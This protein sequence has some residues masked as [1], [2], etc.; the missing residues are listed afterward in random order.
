[1]AKEICTSCEVKL[2]KE[3]VSF[4]PACGH[5]TRFAS[6][7]ERLEHDLGKWR[8][9]L[10]RSAATVTLDAPSNGAPKSSVI[11]A[12]ASLAETRRTS[13]AREP[14]ETMPSVRLPKVRAPRL[15]RRE[16]A[17]RQP[18]AKRVIELDRDHA[19]AYRACPTCEEADWIVRMTRND[20]ATWNFWCVRCS[21]SFK[22][23][24]KLSYAWRPFASAGVVIGGLIA[25]STLMLR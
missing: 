22:T 5:P 14:R 25:A 6:D 9:H 24:V 12:T 4:C 2:G 18:K 15:P 1:M 23:E 21:R 8:T 19:F 13:V 16:R 7:A 3:Q 20:D 10:G 17:E 11:V